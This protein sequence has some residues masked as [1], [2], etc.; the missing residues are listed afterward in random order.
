[1]DVLTPGDLQ[2]AVPWVALINRHHR[3]D[4]KTLTESRKCRGILVGCKAATAG[5]FEVDLLFKKQ[6]RL[7]KELREYAK[8]L[9]V[10]NETAPALVVGE[11]VFD[12]T[13]HTGVVAGRGG[14]KVL[15]PLSRR[16]GPRAQF[17]CPRLQCRTWEEPLKMHIAISV[18]VGELVLRNYHGDSGNAQPWP[19]GMG[20]PSLALQ[21][22][23]QPHPRLAVGGFYGRG[24]VV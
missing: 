21:G 4:M 16:F 20:D 17:F 8:Q 1:M 13:K 11:K 22:P 18:P 24:G 9:W 3:S 6:A 10:L 12:S 2:A 19:G 14:F 23:W 5:E 15:H 7:A